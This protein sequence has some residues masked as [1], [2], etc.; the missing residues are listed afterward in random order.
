MNKQLIEYVG[1]FVLA[2]S[3]GTACLIFSTTSSALIY[4]ITNLCLAIVDFIVARSAYRRMMEFAGMLDSSEQTQDVTNIRITV[5]GKEKSTQ[6]PPQ[7]E[8]SDKD[9]SP[10]EPSSEI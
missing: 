5:Y 2:M 1:L 3:A 7:G 4:K 6:K 10:D 8:A 9:E